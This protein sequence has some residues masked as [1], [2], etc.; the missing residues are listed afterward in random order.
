MREV[1]RFIL[2]FLAAISVLVGVLMSKFQS[3]PLFLITFILVA[4]IFIFVVILFV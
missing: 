1:F 2:L 4:L 3:G